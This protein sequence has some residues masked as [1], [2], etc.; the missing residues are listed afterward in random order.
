[1]SAKELRWIQ[2]LTRDYPRFEDGRIDYTIARHCPVVECVVVHDNHALLVHRSE[3]VLIY[4]N[5]WGAVTGFIDEIKPLREIV[6]A[7]LHEEVGIKAGHIKHLEIFGRLH[8]P[9]VRLERDWHVF[10]SLAVL[11]KKPAIKTNW[12]NKKAE[13]VPLHRV[14]TYD[15]MPG[16]D[17]S[18]THVVGRLAEL[19]A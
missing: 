18:F 14:L 4:P 1:M 11:H 15:L 6:L 17:Q 7:E 16:F 13:W 9:D 19:A 12:E 10:P 2:N 8:Q 3:Q 5:S